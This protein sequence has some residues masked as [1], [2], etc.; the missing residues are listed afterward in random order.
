[1]DILRLTNL[2]TWL[3]NTTNEDTSFIKFNAG[4]PHTHAMTFGKFK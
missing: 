3:K 1:M 4:A 2:W